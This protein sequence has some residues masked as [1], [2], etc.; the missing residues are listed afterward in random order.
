MEVSKEKRD[1]EGEWRYGR[2]MAIEKE[3]AISS[4]RRSLNRVEV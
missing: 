4:M 3:L 1:L 2:R